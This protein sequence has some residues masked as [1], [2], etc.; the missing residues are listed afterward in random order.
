MLSSADIKTRLVAVASVLVLSGCSTLLPLNYKGY[1]G[2]DAATLVVQQRE[3]MRGMLY[4]NFYEKKEDC[5][6]LT[7]SYQL[8]PDMMDM[9]K[10]L[11]T[12]KIPPGKLIAVQKLYSAGRPV[13]TM[14]SYTTYTGVQWIPLIAQPGKRYYVAANYG[15]REIPPDYLITAD[16][17]PRK[18]FSE[19]KQKLQPN[20]DA[21][22]RCKHLLSAD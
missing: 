2:S 10:K 7:D 1:T 14:T 11:I 18:V 12:Q 15:V 22:K 3:D 21:N 4:I 13:L 5:F 9:G 6:D 20:W 16:T 8:S 17:D 19:F